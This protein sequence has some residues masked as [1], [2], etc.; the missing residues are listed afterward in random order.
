MHLL[1]VKSKPLSKLLLVRVRI[2]FSFPQSPKLGDKTPKTLSVFFTSS[3]NIC[4]FTWKVGKLPLIF[5][6][7]RSAVV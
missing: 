7:F 4:C 1:G 3:S 6:P 2:I 5:D